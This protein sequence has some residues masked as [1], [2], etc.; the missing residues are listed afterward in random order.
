M[1]EII[2]IKSHLEAIMLSGQIATR[3]TYESFLSAIGACAGAIRQIELLREFPDDAVVEGVPRNHRVAV[4]NAFKSVIVT[5]LGEIYGVEV[6]GF[7]DE[8]R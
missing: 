8:S 7:S 6:V 1:N 4:L 3:T 5:R 2:N